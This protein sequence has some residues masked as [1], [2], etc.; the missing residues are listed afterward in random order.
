MAKARYQHRHGTKAN[1]SASDVL[2]DEAVIVDSG[3]TPSSSAMYYKPSGGG[4]VRLA[5]F[6]DIAAGDNTMLLMTAVSENISEWKRGQIGWSGNKPVVKTGVGSETTN[7]AL[8]TEA[9]VDST[10]GAIETAL[11]NI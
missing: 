1:L 8:A 7:V 9:Y 4:L 5:N 3:D 6:S 11:S 2:S 10:L